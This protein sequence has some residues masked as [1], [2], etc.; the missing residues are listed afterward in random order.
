VN[1]RAVIKKITAKLAG[2][3]EVYFRAAK[4][5]RA[6][7]THEQNK[8]ENKYDTRGLEAS[9]LAHG[10]S[11]Q[12]AEIEAAIVEFEKLSSRPFTNGDGIGVGALITLE[13]A[14]EQ[15]FYFL[16]PRAGGTEVV[17]DRK[18]ILVIT[19]QSPLGEQLMGRKQGDQPQLNLGGAKQTAKIITVE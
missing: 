16:G 17:H 2:E 11:R 3:L 1:K 14:G 8:A 19:P 12:A 10:Q 9:Y 4:F 18:E 7:A 15:L 13:V 5:A 6:E